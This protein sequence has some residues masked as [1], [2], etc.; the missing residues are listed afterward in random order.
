MESWPWG[1]EGGGEG[2]DGGKGGG[3]AEGGGGDAAVIR[4]GR[5]RSRFAELDD[6]LKSMGKRIKSLKGAPKVLNA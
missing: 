6:T 5:P 1:P 2:G 3:G 4:R